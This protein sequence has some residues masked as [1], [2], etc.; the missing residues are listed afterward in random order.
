M[1]RDDVYNMLEKE[2]LLTERSRN[3]HKERLKQENDLKQHQGVKKEGT[4]SEAG[5]GN[6][7]G[8]SKKIQEKE[9]NFQKTQKKNLT[10]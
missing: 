7:S 1:E 4:S 6:I 2:G 9:K 3:A 5:G 10:S 8:F